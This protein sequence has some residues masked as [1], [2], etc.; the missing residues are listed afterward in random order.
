MQVGRSWC[1]VPCWGFR[2]QRRRLSSIGIGVEC[3]QA[4]D[5]WDGR[6][7]KQARRWT[8]SHHIIHTHS[9]TGHAMHTRQAPQRTLCWPSVRDK[10]NHR[11]VQRW[12]VAILM[13]PG[14]PSSLAALPAL[15]G[16]QL[17]VRTVTTYGRAECRPC[18][19][20]KGPSYYRFVH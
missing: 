10:T 13:P 5:M 4:Y 11:S 17:E 6:H 12:C 2:G 16:A 8:K 1:S 3:R 14:D 19:P 18:T 15:V 7:R 20:R 9:D